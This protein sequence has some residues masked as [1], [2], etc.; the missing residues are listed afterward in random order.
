MRINDV[1]TESKIKN[2]PIFEDIY[3]ISR[4]LV[5]RNLSDA[6]IAKVFQAV[7]DGAAKGQNDGSNRT[8]LGKGAD[9]VTSVS[10]AFDKIKDKISKSGP[11]AGFDAAFDKMQTQILDAAGGDA[12][13]LGKAI[14]SYREFAKKHPVMQG[15][16]Y[17]G[18]IALAGI[19]GAGLGGA[20][21]LGGVKLFDRLLQGDK[22]SSA[23]WK[24]FKTGAVAA[25]A[26]QVGQ[27]AQ[28]DAATA[29]TPAS[30]DVKLPTA[31][32]AIDRANEINNPRY[33]NAIT[34][35][36]SNNS[37]SPAFKQ[38]FIK[39]LKDEVG[40]FPSSDPD[41][42]RANIESAREAASDAAQGM[43]E[44]IK[45]ID[46][47]HTI[48]TWALNESL[49]RSR[50]GV[51]ITTAGVTKIFESV[52][53]E[54][55]FTDTVKSAGSKVAGVAGKVAGA[56]GSAAKQGWQDASNKITYNKLDLNWRR[57]EGRDQTGPVDSEVLAGFLRKQGVVDGLIANVY[58]SMKIP[59][60]P[61]AG[62]DGASAPA[63]QS[64]AQ[65]QRGSNAVDPADNGDAVDPAS[66]S[67]AQPQTG[68]DAV[69]PAGSETPASASRPQGGGK[70]PGQL[71]QTPSAVRRRQSRMARSQSTDSPQQ[72]T[73]PLAA[74]VVTYEAVLQAVQRLERPDKVKLKNFLEKNL[75]SRTKKSAAEPRAAKVK[76][77]QTAG[78][79]N[80]KNTL[81]ESF[82]IYR[83][84]P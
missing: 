21:L 48:W 29:D 53:N 32:A 18:L 52:V 14:S 68:S 62:T 44:S 49:G 54:G 33:Q 15:A 11:V 65:S 1:L 4:L 55:P 69:E 73:D 12:G 81:A 17:A 61:A 72:T 70:V 37:F 58:K 40:N 45:Y 27:A 67:D 23:L 38:E 80:T 25:A 22:A 30:N 71:S 82:S 78:L 75:K 2:D 6:D 60:K 42:V 13:E 51:M 31:D 39:A 76:T 26:G 74:P 63:G 57:G 43:Y 36:Q 20:A 5:E 3:R 10:Q 24:G 64:A 56:V 8:V 41:T 83:K 47:N 79:N 35:V 7:A 16:V 66:G 77:T 50:G 19:S 34:Q 28:G 9:A 59:F 46:R 84:R